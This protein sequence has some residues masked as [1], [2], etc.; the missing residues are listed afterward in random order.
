M[1]I[2]NFETHRSVQ[3]DISNYRYDSL[4]NK[5]EVIEL[6]NGLSGIGYKITES[7]L[8]F[9]QDHTISL[10]TNK[11]STLEEL[12]G[13]INDFGLEDVDVIWFKAL[14]GKDIV[15]GEIYPRGN[16]LTIWVPIKKN[17]LELDE[18]SKMEM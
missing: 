12:I 17:E 4:G 3:S 14:C 6:I 15:Q 1:K 5:E 2:I 10:P 18:E 9:Q 8:S 11:F 16:L 7:S 13:A